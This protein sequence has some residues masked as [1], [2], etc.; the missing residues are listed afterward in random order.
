RSPSVGKA[1]A[2]LSDLVLVKEAIGHAALVERASRRERGV[3][4]KLD[5]AVEAEQVRVELSPSVVCI[6]CE[7]DPIRIRIRDAEDART[8]IARAVL[9]V[10]L[11]LL[12][13]GHVRAA[14]A[15]RPRSGAPHDSRA[16][17]RNACHGRTTRL[18]R[19]P[20]PANSSSTT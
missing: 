2:E 11:E 18:R 6:L 15:Q 4:D 12:V 5:E 3:G 16:D 8:P 20:M 10:E 13:H 19:T 17:D 1:R 9:V 14:L 7:A